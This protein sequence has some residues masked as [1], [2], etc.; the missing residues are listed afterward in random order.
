[1]MSKNFP[2]HG[3]KLKTLKSADGKRGNAFVA[4]P[5]VVQRY[6]AMQRAKK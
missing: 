4:P 5:S 6:E 3:E 2:P 1:M